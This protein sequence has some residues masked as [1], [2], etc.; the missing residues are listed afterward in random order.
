MRFD[1]FVTSQ[2]KPRLKFRVTSSVFWHALLWNELFLTVF[3]HLVLPPPPPSH[4]CRDHIQREQLISP[5]GRSEP[6]QVGYAT[7]NHSFSNSCS[8]GGCRPLLVLKNVTLTVGSG[9]LPFYWVYAVKLMVRKKK[10]SKVLKKKKKKNISKA[11]TS[12]GAS[13]AFQVRR[14][15]WLLN[16]TEAFYR[17]L[18]TSNVFSL[19]LLSSKSLTN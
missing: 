4:P 1:H 14:S 12:M 10:R 6:C 15:E 3:S 5:Q 16:E 9:G 13:A 18:C 8:V 7:L 11:R 17:P 19:P 2:P